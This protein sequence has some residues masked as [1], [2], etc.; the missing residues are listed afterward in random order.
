MLPVEKRRGQG[1]DGAAN[2]SGHLSGV[3]ARMK[4]KEPRALFVHCFGHCTNL[5]LQDITK[6]CTCVRDAL[7]LASD[8]SRLIMSSAQRYTLF[9]KI[10]VYMSSDAHGLRP[11]CN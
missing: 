4:A 5:T 1:F 3:A 2:M 6:Q 11:L 9:Q 8:I 7:D 10:K